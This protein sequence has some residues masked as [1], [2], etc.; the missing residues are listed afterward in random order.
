MTVLVGARCCIPLVHAGPTLI[1]PEKILL[2]ESMS[3]PRWSRCPQ[4]GAK[5]AKQW[6]K[7]NGPTGP[8]AKEAA[9]GELGL[10]SPV[11]IQRRSNGVSRESVVEASSP[12]VF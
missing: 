8:T 10:K 7:L 11:G 9:D 1:L 2:Q 12:V 6:S 4:Q 3:S 5:P